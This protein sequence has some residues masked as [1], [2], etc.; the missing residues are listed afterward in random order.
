MSTSAPDVPVII[1]VPN[2]D[3]P[4]TNTD[5]EPLP[6]I[7]SER[8][9]NLSWTLGHFKSRMEMVTGIPPE[10][11]KVEVRGRD[12]GEWMNEEDSVGRWGVSKGEVV[13]IHDTRP[14]SV[15]AQNI[16][17]P[18]GPYAV[19]KYEMPTSAYETLSDSVLSWKKNN[20]L[21][22]FNPAAPT[23]EALAQARHE[24]DQSFIESQQIKLDRRC[25]VG[26]SDTRRGVVKFIGE[27][28]EI[29]GGEGGKE[30][31][32]IWIGVAFDE[33]VGKNDGTIKGKRYFECQGEKFGGFIRPEIVECG[34]QWGVLDDLLGDEKD[35]DMEEI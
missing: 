24:R 31:G 28:P 34:E 1:L 8:R 23:P 27:V 4:K 20:R 21:G 12:V 18:N 35:D 14:P 16:F 10:S 2:E 19:P 7:Q 15:R 30:R 3:G 9:I 22:R 29:G 11:M 17:D 13:V 33:P 5:Q 25:R 32:A 6:L 26:E